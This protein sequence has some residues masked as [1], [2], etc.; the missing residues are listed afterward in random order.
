[1]IYLDNASTTPPMQF[2]DADFG[3]PSSPHALGIRAE[4]RLAECRRETSKIIGCT[5]NELTFTSGGTESNNL[6]IVG[7][8]L[9]NKRHAVTIFAE[10]WEHP[11]I[12]E[13]IKFVAEHFGFAVQIT[14]KEEWRTSSGIQLACFSHVNHETGDINNLAEIATTLKKQNS[15]TVILADGAQG[16]CKELFDFKSTDMYSFSSHKIHASSGVGGLAIRNGI[17]LNPLF[18]GGGQEMNLRPGTENLEGIVK[19]T[20]AAKALSSEHKKNHTH[21]AKIKAIFE[22]LNEFLPNIY[23]NSRS[24]ETSPYI[25]NISFLGIKGETL[26]HLLSEKGIYASMGAACRSR[27][28]VK[29]SL[30]LMGF[31]PE[32]VESAVRFSFSHMNT[33][34]EALQAKEIIIECVNQLR[35][36]IGVR[37]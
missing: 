34:E 23:I 2:D 31:A 1:M 9:A 36:I 25:L 26:V 18:H 22:N 17:R 3:N 10:P 24:N 21:T 37:R 28:K 5:E 8:A 4:R 27:K 33:M 11:S 30:E 7:F 15:S 12:I 14:P 35:R 32:R 6:A 20:H 16:F 13:P 19:T 29:T